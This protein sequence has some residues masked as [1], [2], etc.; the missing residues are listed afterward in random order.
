MRVG[1]MVDLGLVNVGQRGIWNL[2]DAVVGVI[3]FVA[4][5]L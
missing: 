2:Y 3:L 5:S 4:I 1:A